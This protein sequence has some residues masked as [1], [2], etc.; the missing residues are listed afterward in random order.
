MLK[1]SA[2]TSMLFTEVPF[3]DRFQRARDAGFGA[4][5]FLWPAGTDLD[6]LVAAKEA[7]SVDVALFNVN[8]GDLAAGERGFLSH[9]HRQEWWRDAFRQALGLA[10]RLGCRCLHTMAGNRLPGLSRQEQLACA[11]DNLR[12]AL[13]Q[14]E[15]AGI[16]A[17]IEV[18]NLFDNPEFLLYHTS[19]AMELLDQID[20]ERVQFQ[21]DAYHIQRME[22]DLI[23]TIRE[24]VDRMGHVQIADSPGRHQPG[25]GEINYR[26]VLAA[27]DD[28]G[29]AGYVGLEYVPLGTTEESL[30]WLPHAARR[31]ASVEDLA[32]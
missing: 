9:P 31:T 20:T 3:L 26:N 12:W 25:T 19:H 23:A 8:E 2:N 10:Q 5:E 1:F 30:A 24:H 29:Y 27:L 6:D 22:G 18:L 21:F 11:V 7:A 16:T 15:A 28:A 13:P 14:L 32:L 17:M 4:A